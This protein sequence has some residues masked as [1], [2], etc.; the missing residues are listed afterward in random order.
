M[1]IAMAKKNG[2]EKRPHVGLGGRERQVY[3]TVL[4]LGNASVAEILA[5]LK[6]APTYDTVRTIVRTLESKGYLK[7]H[8][9]GNKYVYSAKH[10]PSTVNRSAVQHLIQ[11]FFKGS[12]LDTVAAVLDASAQKLTSEEVEQ[13]EELIRKAKK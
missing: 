9:E 12:T 7:H 8:T 6:D 11:T 5:E 3:E 1:E 10:S 2:P 13:L 4:R